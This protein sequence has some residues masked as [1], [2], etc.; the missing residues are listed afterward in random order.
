MMRRLEIDNV[1]VSRAAHV[2]YREITVSA[3]KIL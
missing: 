2:L 1:G 3:L